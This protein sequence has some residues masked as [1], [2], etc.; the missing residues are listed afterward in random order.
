M[1][2][3]FASRVIIIDEDPF[4]S[5][6]D[7]TKSHGISFFYD[8]KLEHRDNKKE[9][10]KQKVVNTNDSGIE[11]SHAITT[12]EWA[13]QLGSS[14][15]TTHYFILDYFPSQERSNMF[16]SLPVPFIQKTNIKS[17]FSN[18]SKVSMYRKTQQGL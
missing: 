8:Q 17:L 1:D 5:T 13:G 18:V 15:I 10:T 16:K 2:E 6:N 12:S 4:T 11:I 7:I 14:N 3:S 9:K